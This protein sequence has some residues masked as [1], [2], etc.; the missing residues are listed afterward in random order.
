LIFLSL[1]RLRAEIGYPEASPRS[2]A[3]V[4]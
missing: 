4:A 2:Q 3:K 1:V